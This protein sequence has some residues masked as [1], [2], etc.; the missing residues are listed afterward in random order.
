MAAWLLVTVWCLLLCGAALGPALGVEVA[1]S[2]A[3][4]ACAALLLWA[5]PP[6]RPPVSRLSVALAGAAGFVALPAWL[7]VV[8]WIGTSL[9]LAPPPPAP[10]APGHGAAA[11]LANVALAPLFEELLYREQLLPALRTRLG[12]PLALLV[13]SALFAAPHLEPWSVLTTFCVGLALGGLFLGSGRVEPCIAHHAALNAGVLVCGL[14]PVR[15]A[16]APPLAALAGGVLL[17]LACACTRGHAARP[18]V[19]TELGTRS[20]ARSRQA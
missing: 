15:A 10:A 17:G 18:L 7:A 2:G 8:W 12:A 5:R 19:H 1:R 16:L 3:Y 11:W 13:S 9:G 6:A 14:P 20:A 4:A